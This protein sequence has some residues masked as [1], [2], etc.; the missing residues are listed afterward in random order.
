MP[1]QAS[2]PM[3][4]AHINSHENS[5]CWQNVVFTT[6]QQASHIWRHNKLRRPLASLHSQKGLFVSH[7]WRILDVSISCSCSTQIIC[8]VSICSAILTEC[9][10]CATHLSLSCELQPANVCQ[11]SCCQLPG[12]CTLCQTV[13]VQ[14]D[15]LIL[16]TQPDFSWS[17]CTLL[18]DDQVPA[19]YLFNSETPALNIYRKWLTGHDD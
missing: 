12:K 7:V 2:K 15:L 5:S 4:S 18:N 9:T 17:Q 14:C 13:S 8:D 19:F 11:K 3:S 10:Q 6:W 16:S 1:L